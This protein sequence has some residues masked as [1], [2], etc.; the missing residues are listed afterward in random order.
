MLKN[1]W[2]ICILSLCNPAL[3]DVYPNLSQDLNNTEVYS[4]NSPSIFPKMTT[5]SE[6]D[7]YLGAGIGLQ[8]GVAG[9]Q[10]GFRN[11]ESKCYLGL[12]YLTGSLGC[13][14][15]SSE[16]SEH[17]IGFNLGFIGA[18]EKEELYYGAG[19]YNYYPSGFNNE[20]MVLGLDVGL[21]HFCVFEC[22]ISPVVFVDIAYQF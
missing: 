10:T 1:I 3:A 22:G 15:I 19:S 20:G 14:H 5:S 17:S 7:F 2:I 9:V 18:G 4:N 11:N 6:M 12:S 21:M 16:N 8:Y 13:Q